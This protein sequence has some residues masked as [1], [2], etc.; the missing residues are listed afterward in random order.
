M[1]KASAQ[2]SREKRSGIRLPVAKLPSR[3]EIEITSSRGKTI[4]ETKP[5]RAR[6]APSLRAR[7]ERGWTMAMTIPPLT[8]MIRP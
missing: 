4:S 7:I 2:C 8:L 6:C 5:I 1:P 3:K